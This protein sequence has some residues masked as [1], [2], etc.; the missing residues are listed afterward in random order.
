MDIKET[1]EELLKLMIVFDKICSDNG[2]SYTLH[3][4]SLLGAI[5][6]KG[7]IPWDDDIDVAMTRS[8]YQK[9]CEVIR[10]DEQVYLYGDIK[11]QF[12]KKSDSSVWID[13]FICD[14]ISDG[15]KKQFKLFKLT[16]YDIMSKD[17][18]SIKLS[19]FDKYC[20]WKR[21]AYKMVYLFG[22]MFSRKYIVD[23]YNKTAEADNLEQ[24]KM[25]HRS[26]DQLVARKMCFPKEWMSEYIYVPFENTELMVISQYDNMLIQCYGNDYMIPMKDERNALVHDIVRG[27]IEL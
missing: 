27:E 24:K 14:F 13:I 17:K 1:Q 16:V 2:I 21:I 22:K 4:G 6:E 23:L 11:K 3:G 15:W 25:M 26:N 5:R 8:E 18:N 20:L 12:R 19:N 10:D 9:F 7:F